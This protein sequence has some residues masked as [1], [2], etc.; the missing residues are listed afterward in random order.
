MHEQGHFY[1]KHL[2][3]LA[4]SNIQSFSNPLLGVPYIPLSSACSRQYAIS[5]SVCWYLHAISYI[6]E[7]SISKIKHNSI[8]QPRHPPLPHHTALSPHHIAKHTIQSLSP[9]CTAFLHITTHP[10]N[11]HHI[12]QN[13]TL[14]AKTVATTIQHHPPP[15]HHIKQQTLPY[16]AF[17]HN[18]HH[19]PKPVQQPPHPTKQHATR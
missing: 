1:N 4:S 18:A 8:T 3:N 15:C 2:V 19:H 9:P 7:H 10:S 11:N 13:Y 16:Q 17:H 14:H 6:P 12:L 5:L